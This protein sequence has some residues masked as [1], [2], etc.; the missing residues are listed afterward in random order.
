LATVEDLRKYRD[1]LV[2]TSDLVKKS[3]AEGKT[4][5]QL[6]ADGLPDKWKGMGGGST[7]TTRWI[8]TIYNDATKAPAR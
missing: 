6:K 5:D 8:E 1:M 4:L 2:T 3:I 7:S